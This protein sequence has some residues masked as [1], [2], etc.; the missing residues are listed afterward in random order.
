MHLAGGD[1]GEGV[2]DGQGNGGGGSRRGDAERGRFRLVHGRGEEDGLG[3]V[4]DELARVR[5]GVGGQEDQGE[6]A[7]EVREEGEQLG[8]LAREGD[9]EEGVARGDLAEVAVQSLGRVQEDGLDGEAVEGG[10]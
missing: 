8:G 1:D 9:E 2:A 5:A 6:G 4:A 3:P 7:V 10:D